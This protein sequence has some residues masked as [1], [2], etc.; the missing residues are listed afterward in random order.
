MA[1]IQAFA[2]ML[3]DRVCR[4]GMGGMV[5]PPLLAAIDHLRQMHLAIRR[6]ESSAV[7]VSHIHVS[8]VYAFIGNAVAVL[9]EFV[10]PEQLPAALDKLRALQA[11]AVVGRGGNGRSTPD[12]A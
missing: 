11:M 12:C 2:D 6:L 8:I 5:P 7:E 4:G 9:T 3:E 1:R 10:A